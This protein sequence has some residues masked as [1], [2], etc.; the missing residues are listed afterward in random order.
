MSEPFR[1]LSFGA[2]Q[3]STALVI[4]IADKLVVNGYDFGAIKLDKV[5]FADT[6]G[7][8][9]ATYRH[10]ER[11]KEY[12]AYRGIHLDVVRAKGLPLRERVLARARGEIKSGAPALPLFLKETA[13]LVT[14]Y[15][16][17]EKG[18]DF[19]P[20]IE[21]RVISG[22]AQQQCTYDFKSQPLDKSVKAILDGANR[23][24]E[25]EILIGFTSEEWM[26][27]RGPRKD[28]PPGWKFRYPM[29]EAGVNRG[30]A[31]DVCRAALGH[32]PVSSAC[33]FCPHRPDTGPGGRKWIKENEPETWAKV[34]ELDA[35]IRTGYMGLVA[36]AYISKLRMPV[37]EALAAASA[38]GELWSEDGSNG[39]DDGRCFT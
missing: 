35:A 9:Q 31:Q 7:E 11:M 32:V 22:K 21:T 28:W 26:R 2:G 1:A 17:V 14:V 34:V 10:I 27:A 24:S 8:L 25:V 30:W 16:D 23:E 37:D 19:E 15:P 3:G 33:A 36:P 12:L 39:C 4:A 18:E 13:H 6:G 20:Y 38:Q 29:I 5:T